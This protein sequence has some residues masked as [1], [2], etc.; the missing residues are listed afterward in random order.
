[1]AR[2][3]PYI[4]LFVITAILLIL[5]FSK[6]D[7]SSRELIWTSISFENLKSIRISNLKEI[8][9]VEREATTGLFWVAIQSADPVEPVSGYFRPNSKLADFVESLNPLRVQRVLDFVDKHSHA[10]YGIEERSTKVSFSFRDTKEEFTLGKR[11]YG[12]NSMYIFDESKKKVLL[13][14]SRPFESLKRI[15][16]LMFERTPFV[17]PNGLENVS[18]TVSGEF[19]MTASVKIENGKWKVKRP[20]GDKESELEQWL[21][22]F[23]KLKVRSYVPPGEVVTSFG[24]PLFSIELSGSDSSFFEKIQ[25]L[26]KKVNKNRNDEPSV[27]QYI[28]HSLHLK[29]YGVIESNA[30]ETLYKELVSLLSP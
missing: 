15:K 12:S 25:I 17:V 29:A 20:D 3:F 8:I 11:S 1:M 23:R 24:R 14:N 26:K 10:E 16:T 13:V 28:I 7:S 27:D 21:S 19:V 4:G 30:A 2:L 9:D 18:V 5:Y 22:H 6:D